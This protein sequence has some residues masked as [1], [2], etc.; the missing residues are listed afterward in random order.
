MCE[1]GWKVLTQTRR[2]AVIQYRAPGTVYGLKVPDKLWRAIS[3]AGPHPQ[4]SDVHADGA[5]WYV[6]IEAPGPGEPR[7]VGLWNQTDANGETL[8]TG[9][10][11][12][13]NGPDA[14]P[15]TPVLVAW[16][17]EPGDPRPGGSWAVIGRDGT[18]PIAPGTISYQ[19]HRSGDRDREM[20]ERS[21]VL[22]G[23]EHPL[24]DR[25]RAAIT[26]HLVRGKSEPLQ[27]AP[28]PLRPARTNGG[29]TGDDAP[30]AAG[31]E[32][33]FV[34]V[35]APEPV[36]SSADPGGADPRERGRDGLDR[37]LGERHYVNAH[38]KRQAHGPGSQ[39]RKIICVEGYW[40][41]P[42]PGDDEIMLTRM[43][44]GASAG[45]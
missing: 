23:G 5:W 29:D 4:P 24:V 43:A 15:E 20:E 30:E 31:S 39:L 26:E 9:I 28:G 36:R 35:R 21:Y 2:H 8:K 22:F 41:G 27:L 34:L 11:I 37:P 16:R 12:W 14:S 40:R 19:F 10:G 45:E 6:E 42:E 3:E 1:L 33:V 32:S 17:I 38:Y 44:E 13:T 18:T 25:V 7:A